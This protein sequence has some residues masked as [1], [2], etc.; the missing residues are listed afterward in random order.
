M[1][2]L[3]LIGGL[4]T[5]LRPLTCNT[6]KPLMPVVNRPFLYYQL[7]LL[8][9]HGIKDVIFCVSYLPESFKRYFGN[10]KK[11]GLRI[12][13]VYEK[14]PLGTGGAIKNAEKHI[15]KP[16]IIFN[17][18]IITDIS[19]SRMRKFHI[20]H[21]ALASIALVQVKNPTAYGLIETDK[22]GRIERF[23]EKPS[24]DE[25]TCNTINAGTYIFQPEVLKFIPEKV[26]YSVERGLFPLLLKKGFPLFGFI[27][28]KY[29]LDVGTTQNYLKAHVDFL[30]RK[31]HY[32]LPGKK[33]K[34]GIWV[35][36]GTKISSRAA[37]KHTVVCGNNTLIADYVQIEGPVCLGNNCYVDKGAFLHNCVVLDSCRIGEGAR[38]EN[39]IVGNHCIIEPHAV[40]GGRT[41]LGDGSVIKRYSRV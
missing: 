6:P 31:I 28:N 3:I 13:Y 37:L 19:I 27:Y 12:T 14:T 36:K 38:L 30:E 23:I 4:G 29:W 39:C 5:R 21:K 18:D 26:N 35:G 34:R 25:V 24:W 17:G 16:V 40:I 7:K 22:K 33:V 9:D 2:A 20:Q 11:F 15:D 41:V 32:S 8:K 10:G 1:K